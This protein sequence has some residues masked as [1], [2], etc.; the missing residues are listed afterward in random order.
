MT[1]T[2]KVELST[3]ARMDLGWGSSTALIKNRAGNRV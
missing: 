1:R 3:D 2:E